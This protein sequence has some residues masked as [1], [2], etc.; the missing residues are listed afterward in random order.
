MKHYWNLGIGGLW[1]DSL[2]AILLRYPKFAG[3]KM[4]RRWGEDNPRLGL[5]QFDPAIKMLDELQRRGKHCWYH[6][7]IK[8]FDDRP[9]LVCPTEFEPFQHK[10]DAWMAPVYLESCNEARIEFLATLRR[11]VG[12]HPA[13][14]CIDGSE[15]APGP[16]LPKSQM[17]AMLEALSTEYLMLA[18]FIIGFANINYFGKYLR[19][20]VRA[21]EPLML[22]A[23]DAVDTEATGLG[24]FKAAEVSEYSISKQGSLQACYNWCTRNGIERIAWP[25]WRA[26]E[27][28]EFVEGLGA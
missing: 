23:T 13:F 14:G 11:Y 4:Q 26:Q 9:M 5:Y 22:S 17:P 25:I 24:T 21:A 19:E 7:E 6:S 27:V 2:A 18:Q 20:L 28:G 16:L 8:R 1:S 15:S 10:P 3:V 12:A